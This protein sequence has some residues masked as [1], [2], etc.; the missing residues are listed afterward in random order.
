[1]T[2]DAAGNLIETNDGGIFKRTRPPRQHR[3]LVLAQQQPQCD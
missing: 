3:R 2:F 1:M